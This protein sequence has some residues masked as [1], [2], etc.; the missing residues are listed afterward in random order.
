MWKCVQARIKEFSLAFFVSNK[1]KGK[2]VSKSISV[3]YWLL[4]AEECKPHCVTWIPF[5]FGKFL[6]DFFLYS[7]STKGYKGNTQDQMRHIPFNSH[8]HF[9]FPFLN[10]SVQYLLAHKKKEE[11]VEDLQIQITKSN[12]WTV[13][14]AQ[15]EKNN[16]ILSNG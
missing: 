8:L 13:E 11:Q 15:S 4:R 16:T 2:Y 5:Y 10:F 6:L 9:V 1:I 14:I 12:I 7:I 3:V